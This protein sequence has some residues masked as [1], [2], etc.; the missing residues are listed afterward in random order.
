MEL[1]DLNFNVV[2][3]EENN[4]DLRP[5]ESLVPGTVALTGASTR[6]KHPR[7]ALGKCFRLC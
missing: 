5:G 3:N 2:F 7:P 4:V 6:C 1:L